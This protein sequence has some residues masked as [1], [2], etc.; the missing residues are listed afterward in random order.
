ML[1]ILGIAVYLLLQIDLGIWLSK[2]ISDETDYIV[3]GRNLGYGLTMFGAFGNFGGEKAALTSPA[4][5]TLVPIL[6]DH[7]VSF[8]SYP[9]FTGCLL[10]FAGYVIVGFWERLAS[11]ND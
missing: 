2:R 9:Y 10:A 5:G 4:L 1:L 11:G 8:I 6:D 7:F 3:A